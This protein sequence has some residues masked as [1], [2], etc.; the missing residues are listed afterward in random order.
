MNNQYVILV[1]PRDNE[2]QIVK[3]YGFRVILLRKEKQFDEIFNVDNV[4]IEI[5]LNDEKN[6]VEKCL[7]LSKQYNIISIFTMN[8]Y[9]IP[10]A[11]LIGKVLNLTY[12][13]PYEARLRC[14]NK[15]MARQRLNEEGISKVQYFLVT[16]EDDIGTNLQGSNFPLVVK[17]SNDSGSK[18]VFL[19]ENE[20]E[21][22]SAIKNMDKVKQIL[23]VRISIVKFSLKNF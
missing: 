8:E 22:L 19:C 21:V 5:D 23:W 11:S 12:Q 14:R 6:V 9:R 20:L 4:P 16:T 1:S 18:N 15:K 7:Q 10:L 3:N 2:I 17:P 13:L